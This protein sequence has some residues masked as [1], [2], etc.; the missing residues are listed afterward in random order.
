MFSDRSVSGGEP[1]RVKQF[2]CLIYNIK[3]YK[4]VASRKMN[5][6]CFANSHLKMLLKT[7][8]QPLG[9]S[10]RLQE[11]R[12]EVPKKGY[13]IS[14]VQFLGYWKATKKCPLPEK[15]LPPGRY[16]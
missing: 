4:Y 6:L 14:F 1:L 7:I 12:G 10:E 9:T 11:S 13:W 2:S 3:N 16:F 15:K 8:G 5:L